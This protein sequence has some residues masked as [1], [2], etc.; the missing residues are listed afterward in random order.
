MGGG[1]RYAGAIATGLAERG[2]GVT[3]VTSH[4]KREQDFWTPAGTPSTI[5]T[6]H[7]TH[8]LTVIRCPLPGLPGQRPALLTWR[9]AMVLLSALPGNHTRLLNKM[10]QKIPPIQGLSTTLAQL[11]GRFDIINGFNLSWEHPLVS[12]HHYA[13]QHNTPFLITPFAH[14][15]EA[16]SARIARNTTMNHQ[17]HLLETA[18]N[19]LVLTDVERDG[20]PQW[21]I[22][23]RQ[24]TVVGSGADPLPAH[25]PTLPD[26][27]KR[28]GLTTP[29]AIF[30][31]RMNYDKGAIHSAQ[32]ISQLR[33]TGQPTTL[34]LVG[35]T[36]PDFT[37][38]YDALPAGERT[39]IQP[40]GPVN[41][42][43]K[44]ALIRHAQLL[45]LPSR[46]DSFGIVLLEAW[47]HSLPVIGA[48]AGGIASVISHE[49][50]GLL[51]PFG[52]VT[53]LAQAIAQLWDNEG[54]REQMGR[55]G[56]DKINRQ[57]NWQHVCDLTLQAY[58]QHT[59]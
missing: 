40:V 1:E 8:N 10:A 52:D 17:K 30:V 34:V 57:Y 13:Q 39:F 16:K 59:P 29:Y 41:D 54:L 6:T 4:A 31:G 48:R 27:Q 11:P 47:Q 35:H 25:L 51:V 20:F 56:R 14:L 53:A 26:L 2:H 12:A 45:L 21:G 42:A 50:D 46:T 15:G 37:R 49:Q 38:F 7:P 28:L 58:H 5:T 22:H 3:V 18:H 32:A 43:D 33:Q 44:H 55:S 19:V 24:T 9:K 23:P 36:T